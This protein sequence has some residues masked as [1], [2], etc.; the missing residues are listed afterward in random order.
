MLTR[1]EEETLAL[2]PETEEERALLK[3]VAATARRDNWKPT[4]P[5]MPPT[6]EDS[7]LL[8]QRS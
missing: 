2:T 1:W 7:A 8:G 4:P 5:S 3:V 6:A